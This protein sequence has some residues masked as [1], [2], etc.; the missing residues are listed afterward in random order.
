M[1][2]P[3]PCVSRVGL[4]LTLSGRRTGGELNPDAQAGPLQRV[5][6][7]GPSAAASTPD[8]GADATCPPSSAIHYES[9]TACAYS[10]GVRPSSALWGRTSL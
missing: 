9:P 2:R 5:V 6:S 7:D 8:G 10:V 3:L 1:Q 4:T